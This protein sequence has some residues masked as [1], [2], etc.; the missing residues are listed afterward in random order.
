L[1]EQLNH[2]KSKETVVIDLSKT[3]KSPTKMQSELS[4]SSLPDRGKMS[5]TNRLNLFSP[6]MLSPTAGSHST[7][8]VANRGEQ[9]I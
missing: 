9:L 4:I 6:N 7:T 5:K 2:T 1:N 8:Q 3:F